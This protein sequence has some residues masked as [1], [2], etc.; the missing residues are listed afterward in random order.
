MLRPLLSYA[1]TSI[2]LL[3]QTGLPVHMHYC[4]GMLET[5][6]VFFNLGCSGHDVALANPLPPERGNL[7]SPDPLPP[8]RGNL[9]VA[10]PLPPERGTNE[11]CCKASSDVHHEAQQGCCSEATESCCDDE[12]A[13]LL[14]EFDSIL[15][16]FEKWNTDVVA[17]QFSFADFGI[18]NIQSETPQFLSSTSDGGPPLY[19]LNGSLIFYA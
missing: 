7:E 12:V 4:K 5:V 16:H 2:I 10:I 9:G 14:H 3:S 18:E 11:A 6:S 13:V 17:T 15:P 19:I 1:L 8:E